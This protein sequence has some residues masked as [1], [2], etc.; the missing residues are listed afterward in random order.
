MV[1]AYSNQTHDYVIRIGGHLSDTRTSTLEGMHVNPLPDGH[2][3]IS[4]QA[5]DQSALFGILIRIRDMGIPLISITRTEH[6][7]D[8]GKSMIGG[9]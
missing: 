9:E 4:G 1:R 2:T 7:N 5:L 3:L 6:T 8:A